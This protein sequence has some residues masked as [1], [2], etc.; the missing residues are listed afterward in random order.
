MT[1]QNR[2]KFSPRHLAIP[3]ALTAGLGFVAAVVVTSADAPTPAVEATPVIPV[4]AEV[5]PPPVVAPVAPVAMPFSGAAPEAIGP[6]ALSVRSIDTVADWK[7][8]SLIVALDGSTIVVYEGTVRHV[9]G[10][11][12]KSSPGL[13]VTDGV[14]LVTWTTSTA[15]MS[16]TSTDLKTWSVATIA[17]RTQRGGAFPSPCSASIVAWVDVPTTNTVT[18]A[19][20]GVGALNVSTLSGA[21]WV[22]ST[23]NTTASIVSC[24][25]AHVAW[26][27]DRSTSGELTKGIDTVRRARLD[28]S[29]EEVVV[30][31]YDPAY[32]EDAATG[33][34]VIG[35]HTVDAQAHVL[36]VVNGA[37]SDVLLDGVGRFVA[38]VVVGGRWLA[39]WA[40]YDKVSDDARDDSLHGTSAN[41][42]GA[43][44]VIEGGAKGVVGGTSGVVGGE[45]V[46]V[47]TVGGVVTVVR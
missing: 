19:M 26:R 34:Y 29:G 16:A 43:P 38:P 36:A 3:A 46:A 45:M 8:G 24:S 39:V 20:D 10:T 47:Y 1:H 21:G 14:A 2:R 25:G 13:A 7:G 22:T 23:L 35:Y 9:V 32:H 30:S 31:G 15:I 40:D 11:A 18:G 42:N 37:R 12:A 27:D 33:D 6:G 28:G 41:Y 4:V 44:V 5:A 17:K